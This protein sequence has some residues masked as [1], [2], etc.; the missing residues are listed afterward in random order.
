MSLRT[1]ILTSLAVAA[2]ACTAP[3]IG[4]YSGVWKFADEAAL[5][6]GLPLSALWFLL[7]IFAVAKYHW[8][9]LWVLAGAIPALYWPV[10]LTIYVVGCSTAPMTCVV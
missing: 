6:S 9:G 1:T 10:A 8:R 3:L 2:A 7:M 4:Y 5:Y